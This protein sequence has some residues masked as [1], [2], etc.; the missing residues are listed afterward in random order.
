MAGLIALAGCGTSGLVATFGN[1]QAERLTGDNVTV[2]ETLDEEGRPIERVSHCA[3]NCKVQ[4]VDGRDKG[5]TLE[6]VLSVIG[7]ILIG[8]AA[9]W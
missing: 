4:K 3:T 2:T 5:R 9:G 8:L 6:K 1:V 7:G